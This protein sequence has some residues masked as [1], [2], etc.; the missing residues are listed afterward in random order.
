MFMENAHIEAGKSILITRNARQCELIAREEIVVGK[1]KTGQIIGGKTQATQR[2]A[3]GT[4]GASTGI[5]TYV[6]AGIDPY[7]EK[8][9]A[10]KDREFK[11]KCD[12]VD[13]IVKLLVYF[14]HNPQK[15]AGGVAEKVEATRQQLLANIDDLTEE[16]KILRAKVELAE[17][18][19][20]EVSG[21][22][23]YGVEVRIAQ[24]MWAAPDDM[25]G[26]TLE[27]R[28]GRIAINR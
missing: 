26:A 20:V 5:K 3:T 8:Q 16:L 25:G 24:Q 18:A 15:G 9:I 17:Q 28:E 11:Q 13:R 23:H 6:Q 12:E 2:I 14:K 22:I 7:L 1:G 21:Q 4:L 10:D 27:L 19:C